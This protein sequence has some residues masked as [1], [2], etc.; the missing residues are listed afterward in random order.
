MMPSSPIQHRIET[1]NSGR[2]SPGNTP[3]CAGPQDWSVIA[4][5]IPS[6]NVRSARARQHQ[7]PRFERKRSNRQPHLSVPNTPAYAKSP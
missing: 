2:L 7:R 3:A 5:Q 1:R 6:S 4:P